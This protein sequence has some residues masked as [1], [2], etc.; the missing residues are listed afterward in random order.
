MNMLNMELIGIVVFFFQKSGCSICVEKNTSMSGFTQI[1]RAAA[2]ARGAKG[3]PEDLERSQ[4][5]ANSLGGFGIRV[6]TGQKIH[7]LVE[8]C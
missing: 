8:K 3:F 6:N 2:P 4:Q 5:M 7:G 1:P